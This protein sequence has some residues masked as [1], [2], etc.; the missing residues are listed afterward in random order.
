MAWTPKIYDR[1]LPLI[2]VHII[3]VTTCVSAFRRLP[4]VGR[5]EFH[6]GRKLGEWSS[7]ADGLRLLVPATSQCYD[8]YRVG[9]T[10]DD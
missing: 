2:L 3:K 10:A 1:L 4:T 8:K 5:R 7:G 6:G 9:I